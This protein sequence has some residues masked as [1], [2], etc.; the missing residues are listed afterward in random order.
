MIS[1][2]E[3]SV[4]LTGGSLVVGYLLGAR[5]PINRYDDIRGEVGRLREQLHL[6]QVYEYVDNVFSLARRRTAK[7]ADETPASS[8][9]GHSDLDEEVSA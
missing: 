5:H 6:E 7:R 1:Q 3:F 8:T 9:W 2:L 4:A